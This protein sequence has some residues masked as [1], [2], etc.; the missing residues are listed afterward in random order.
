[1]DVTVPGYIH[2]FG[3]LGYPWLVSICWQIFIFA[4]LWIR[5]SVVCTADGHC[6][7]GKSASCAV[8]L[9]VRRIIILPFGLL[10]ISHRSGTKYRQKKT[11][12]RKWTTDIYS[13]MWT[14]SEDVKSVYGSPLVHNHFPEIENIFTCTSMFWGIYTFLASS[15]MIDWFI[16]VGRF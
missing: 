2:I 15:D 6:E 11:I 5:R 9:R 4:Q 3:I 7:I 10:H 8:L 12:P 14:M 16:F 13:S 1:M